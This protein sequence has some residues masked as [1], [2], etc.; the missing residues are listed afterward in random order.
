MRGL[1]IDFEATDKDVNTARI[2]QVALSLYDIPNKKELYHNSH[3]VLPDGDFTFDPVAAQI[4][5]LSID[6]LNEFGESLSYTLTILERIFQNCQYIIAHNLHQYDLP[7]FK[8]ELKRLGREEFQLPS[9]IDTRFDVPWPEHI[10]TR[11]LAYLGAEYGIVNPSAHSAR[12]DVDIM[13][14][15]FFMFPFEAIAERAS[16]PQVWVRANVS[17]ENKDK[18]RNRRFMWDA[19]NKWWVKLYK[20]CDLEKE[21]FDFEYFILKNYQGP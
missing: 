12:H 7:L 6:Q 15:L 17:Y 9:L 16:S 3:L 10:E 21:T 11:K 19:K 1:F 5:G 4:T 18:A 8:N 13:A 20:Q 2:T 14:K